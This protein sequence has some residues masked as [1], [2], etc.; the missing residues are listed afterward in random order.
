MLPIRFDLSNVSVTR[1]AADLKISNKDEYRHLVYTASPR[2]HQVPI[3]YIGMPDPTP[4]SIRVV[5]ANED[6]ETLDILENS[7]RTRFRKRF[8]AKIFNLPTKEAIITD[9]T[10]TDTRGQP[11]P[12]FY[13]HR[14]TD[15]LETTPEILDA[16]MRPVPGVKYKVVVEG[17]NV[18]VFHSLKPSF[19]P[20]NFKTKI[21]YI[22]Y[23]NTSGA[24]VFGILE[25][26]PAFRK[27]TIVDGFN[28]QQRDYSVRKIGAGFEY[29]IIYQGVG[30]FHVLIDD[31]YQL[32]VRKPLFLRPND[33]WNISI[34]DGE[35]FA[36]DADGMADFYGIPEYHF[37]NFAPIEPTKLSGTEECLVL[38]EHTIK[39]PFEN[40]TDAKL[41]ILVCDK[42]MNPKYGWTTGPTN[43]TPF[44]VDRFD[45]DRPRGS[46]VR[47]P[48]E[49]ATARGIL[50]GK[51]FGVAQLPV[52][53]LSDDRV[54]V[55]AKYNTK[56]FKYLGLNLNPLH[57]RQIQNGK[58]IIYC[59]PNSE[60][61]E[62]LQGIYHF[63]LD[64]DNSIVS[65]ND[66][67]LGENGVLDPNLV[68]GVGETGYGLFKTEHPDFLIIASVAVSRDASPTD[69]TYID[70]RQKGGV[71][72]RE[73]RRNLVSL[74]E[75]YPELQWVDDNSLSGRPVP[76]QGAFVIDIPFSSTEAG[77]G[78]HED[79]E[80]ESIV[81]RHMALGSAPIVRYYADTPNLAGM[82]WDTVSKELTV[83]WTPVS[84]AESYRVWVGVQDEGPFL[85]FD[86]TGSTGPVG[87]LQAAIGLIGAANEDLHIT[88]EDK[89]YAYVTPLVDNVAWPGSKIGCLDI[90]VIGDSEHVPLNANLV[91]PPTHTTP[92]NANLV[93]E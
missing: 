54:F 34:S 88:A 23:T 89:L 21:Y 6:P 30:P 33:A 2:P 69:L 12:L 93:S 72:T 79:T 10:N 16:E 42:G 44:W 64:A 57:N 82:E 7:F 27:V 53:L 48:L 68:P 92:L 86:S 45:R 90:S 20:E 80:I 85:Y 58:A 41:D 29:R 18:D 55:R 91:S 15:G 4:S 78:V 66:N 75:T 62:E 70:V 9:V 1:N 38:S 52:R 71:L 67:R 59:V 50:I 28:P 8:T 77:G 39:F 63:I 84:H 73:K 13:R 22:R 61:N 25:N 83:L 24:Q 31:R 43:P 37:Q 74:L 35:L 81:S 5:D 19:N 76:T 3:S 26:E 32:K 47:L 46:I 60:V 87:S 49:S 11:L 40:V 65:W 56:D 36:N 51:T 14:I 17:G